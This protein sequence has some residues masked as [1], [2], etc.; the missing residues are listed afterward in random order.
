[1]RNEVENDSEEKAPARPWAE[2]IPPYPSENLSGCLCRMREGHHVPSCASRGQSLAVYGVF[3]E[4][5]KGL[6]GESHQEEDKN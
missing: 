3:Q 5:K 2:T 1:M 4:V 6:K